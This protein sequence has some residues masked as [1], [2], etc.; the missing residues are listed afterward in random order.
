MKKGQ[1]F[2]TAAAF[3]AILAVPAFSQV[4]I[5]LGAFGGTSTQSPSTLTTQFDSDTTFVYGLRAG[6]RILMVAVELNYFQAAHN[7]Q[8]G[9]GTI[10]PGWDQAVN[11]YSYIGVNGKLYFP[12]LFLQPFV[13]VGYGYYT[14]DIHNIDKAND[15][16]FNFGAGLDLKLGSR[17]SL[18]AEGR[19][20]KISVSIQDIDLDLGDFTLWGGLQFHF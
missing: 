4:G 8:F 15:G 12:L 7:L 20:H 14:A 6:V 13:T 10:L 19:W 2:L 1:V 5:Y 18:T 9:G 3:L 17:F 11:D 16:G